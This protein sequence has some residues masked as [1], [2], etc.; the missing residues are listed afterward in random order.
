MAERCYDV[1]DAG[2]GGQLYGTCG[3]A[4]ALGAEANLIHRLLAR[5]IDNAFVCSGESGACLNE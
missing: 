5:N 4:K 1:F 3:E 2:L